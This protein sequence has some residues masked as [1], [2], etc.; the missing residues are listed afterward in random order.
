MNLDFYLHHTHTKNT[1]WLTDLAVRAKTITLIEKKR[2]K[3][4]LQF[5]VKQKEFLDMITT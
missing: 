3:K 4:T 1:K 2:R 5:V